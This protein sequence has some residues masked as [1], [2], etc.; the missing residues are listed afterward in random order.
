MLSIIENK[1]DYTSENQLSVSDIANFDYLKINTISVTNLNK[2]R[3]DELYSEIINC[4]NEKNKRIL[5]LLYL[6]VLIDYKFKNNKFIGYS[7][8]EGNDDILMSVTDIDTTDLEE[9]VK[10]IDNVFLKFKIYDFISSK[11]KKDKLKYADLA[12]NTSFNF[13]LNNENW[14]FISNSLM[15]K[16]VL[17]FNINKKTKELNIKRIGNKVIAIIT[18]EV[19]EK[20]FDKINYN[21]C[22]NLFTWLYVTRTVDL[23][24]WHELLKL[25]LDNALEYKEI[26]TIINYY[27]LCSMVDENNK[28]YYYKKKGE[29]LYQV[30]IENENN[31]FIALFY[32]NNALNTFRMI[33][34]KYRGKLNV[35]VIISDIKLKLQPVGKDIS[36]NLEQHEV[37]SE[38]PKELIEQNERLLE[39]IENTPDIVNKLA[40]FFLVDRT[41]KKETVIESS[42]KI[43]NNSLHRR[44]F[45]LITLSDDGR[46][47]KRNSSISDDDDNDMGKYELECMQQVG[48]HASLISS[49]F[50]EPAISLLNKDVDKLESA[51]N[52]IVEASLIVP[53]DRHEILRKIFTFG[54]NNDFLTAIHLLCPQIENFIR[55]MLKYSGVS[56]TTITKENEEMELGLSSLLEKNEICDVFEEDFIFELKMIMST[57]GGSN[58]RNNLAHGLLNDLSATQASSKYIWWRFLRIVFHAAT[59][60][61]TDE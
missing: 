53:N 41:I 40:I 18:N 33:P 56:T 20:E 50:I 44:L 48:I 49:L 61:L 52:N 45:S 26:Q 51:I 42:K 57:S 32:L 34:N 19:K 14:F 16:T 24:H 1:A 59:D 27:D 22:F 5:N 37:K 38:L 39:K 46:V 17:L 8:G 13:E 54:F 3:M 55:L 6:I 28:L 30:A 47:I 7:L 25:A 29:F 2:Y 58:L 23:S 35:N 10:N 36:K 15:K 60:I 9:I 31:Q 12:I 11:K 43:A 4:C 21:W